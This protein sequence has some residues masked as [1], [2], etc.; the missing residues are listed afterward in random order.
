MYYIHTVYI[1]IRPVD[2]DAHCV[3]A[4]VIISTQCKIVNLLH[5]TILIFAMFNLYDTVTFGVQFKD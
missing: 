4:G 1:N 3:I 5:Y 2:L